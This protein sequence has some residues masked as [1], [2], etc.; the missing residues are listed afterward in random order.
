MTSVKT[1]DVYKRQVEILAFD[2]ML[3]S[4]IILSDG[5]YGSTLEELAFLIKVI[6]LP[7][8]LIFVKDNPE[9]EPSHHLEF[10]K[11]SFVNL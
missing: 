2:A 8:W 9:E 1:K 3:L 7:F 11:E 6:A 10:G 5:T 4:L